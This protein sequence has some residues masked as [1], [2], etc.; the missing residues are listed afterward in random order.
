MET[1][2]SM[3]ATFGLLIALGLRHGLD[4]DHIAAIDALTKQRFRAN[5]FWAAR[6]TGLQF[7]LGHS[8]TVFLATLLFYW[9]VFQLPTWLDQLGLWISSAVLIWLAAINL[10]HCLHGGEHAHLGG[11]IKTWLM[12][13]MGPLA[14]P[15]GVGFAFAISF[16]SLAQA[17][18]MAAKGH[19]LGGAS[20][21]VFM[22]VCFG[23]GM[24]CADTCNGLVMHLLIGKSHRL[25]RN[26]ARWMSALIALLSLLVVASGHLRQHMEPLNQAMEQAGGWLGAGLTALVALALLLA[27]WR[28]RQRHGEAS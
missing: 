27:Q 19:E 13:A 16:D 15:M 26:S 18:L 3:M 21:V 1:T 23:L 24:L 14:H 10:R 12:R 17:G 6:L 28:H 11:P 8:L 7:A 5:A 2:P 22:P 9:Q 4:P 25:A 20:A